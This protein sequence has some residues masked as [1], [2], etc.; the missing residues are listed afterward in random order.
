MLLFP[1][2]LQWKP[3]DIVIENVQGKRSGKQCINRKVGDVP[4]CNFWLP[5]GFITAQVLDRQRNR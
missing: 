4:K 1:K 3:T 2:K 5:G